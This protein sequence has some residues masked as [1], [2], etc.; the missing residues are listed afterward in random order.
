MPRWTRSSRAFRAGHPGFRSGRS[1]ARRQRPAYRERPDLPRR[2]ATRT[3][4]Y[5][6]PYDA[7]R[8]AAAAL[9][10]VQGL[11][12]T[13]RGG[14]IAIQD[15]VR[16]QFGD[17]GRPSVRSAGSGAT[18]T[19]TSTRTPTRPAPTWVTS[20]TRWRYRGTP[21]R[22]PTPLWNRASS[23]S[24]PSL[25]CFSANECGGGRSDGP[26]VK[27][28]PRPTGG[29]YGAVRSER[30]NVEYGDRGVALPNENLRS[31]VGSG[32]HGSPSPAPTT[33]MRW[34]VCR[35]AGIRAGAGRYREDFIWRTQPEGDAAVMG[36][37]IWC[38][39]RFAYLRLAV[40]GNPTG[41]VPAARS[42]I[43]TSRP[44]RQPLVCLVAE[45]AVAVHALG[46]E[47]VANRQHL[48][49]REKEKVET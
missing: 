12:A 40:K 49:I 37:P 2:W 4:A 11:R 17:R 46:D 21:W 45:R 25:A 29:G 14:H 1:P 34:G 23:A 13:S 22:P 15:A 48:L 10:A 19:P 20:R 41:S 43:A 39:T 26:K 35:A 16:A 36:T 44:A 5:Q 31:I 33:T 7:L 27:G 38:C 8:K 32:V 6:P 3:G 28:S 30:P 9:L 18:A 24:G 47:V 42:S